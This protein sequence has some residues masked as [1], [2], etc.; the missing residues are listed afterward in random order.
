[1]SSQSQVALADIDD[2][3][4]VDLS[5][6]ADVSPGRVSADLV[7]D[8]GIFADVRAPR[9]PGSPSRSIVASPDPL[10]RG[11]VA[12]VPLVAYA[13]GHGQP[14]ADIVANFLEDA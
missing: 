10:A 14:T 1:V 6:L 3:D 8:A 7:A 2:G 12:P 9:R 11:D 4:V 5:L 13:E